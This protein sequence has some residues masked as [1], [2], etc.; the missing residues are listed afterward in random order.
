MKQRS[1]QF[2]NYSNYTEAHSKVY[3]YIYLVRTV[4]III[5][6]L[7]NVSTSSL[8]HGRQCH[9]INFYEFLSQESAGS[10]SS[11][12]GLRILKLRVSQMMT[13]KQNIY[14]KQ[15]QA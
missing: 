4:N 15:T 14:C 11:S 2:E 9:D 8:F 3:I 13:A 5:K 10:S 7:L 12:S 1:E 6:K